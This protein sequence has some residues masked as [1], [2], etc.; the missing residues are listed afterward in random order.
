MNANICSDKRM[1][2]PYPHDNK[3][4]VDEHI[5]PSICCRGRMWMMDSSTLGA[6]AMQTCHHTN[7][8]LRLP[9]LAMR[10]FKNGTGRKGAIGALG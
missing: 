8:T 7:R 2:G 3:E 9:S 5:S 4:G 6:H 10:A 1:E